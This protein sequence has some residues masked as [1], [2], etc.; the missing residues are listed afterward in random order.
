MI[1][2][3]KPPPGKAAAAKEEAKKKKSASALPPKRPTKEA[4]E[5]K[6]QAST[7]LTRYS[8]DFTGGLGAFGTLTDHPGYQTTYMKESE[9]EEIPEGT[10]KK[11]NST[12]DYRRGKSVG[13]GKKPAPHVTKKLFGSNAGTPMRNTIDAGRGNFTVATERAMSTSRSNADFFPES[14]ET[15]LSRR[16]EEPHAVASAGRS[17]SLMMRSTMYSNIACPHC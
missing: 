4:S 15:D 10:S 3:P 12:R 1:H 17:G 13:P 6:S 5:T 7:T 9:L 14:R 16:E 11:G 8:Q 2:R